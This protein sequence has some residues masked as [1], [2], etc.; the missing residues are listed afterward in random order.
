[1]HSDGKIQDIKFDKLKRKLT[2][3]FQMDKAELDF[4]IYRIMNQKREELD[5]FIDKD[6]RAMVQNEFKKYA[7]SKSDIVQEE[8]DRAV[9]SA[10]D[11]G[12]DP[13]TVEKVKELRNQIK[14]QVNVGDTEGEIYSNLTDFF[15]RYYDGGDFI[16][17]RRYK[18]GVYAIPY[19]GEEVKLHWANSNQYYIKTS[20]NF[21]NYSFLLD[22]GKKISFEI[23][24]AETEKDNNKASEG[25]ER[26]FILLPESPTEVR[27]DGNELVIKFEYRLGTE[28]QD[29]LVQK[30]IEVVT[31][32]D[33][34]SDFA[35]M[36][37]MAPTEKNKKRTV[38]EKWLTHYTVKNSFDYFI[39][40]NLRSFLNQELDFYIKNELLRIDDLDA[41]SDAYNARYISK[42]KVFKHIAKQVI[43]FLAQLEDFQK[44]LWEKKKF[45][46][47]SEYVLTL[48]HIDEKH[49]E[50]ILDNKEQKA[51]WLRLGF[52]QPETELSVEY[53][54]T[55]TSLQLDTK[56]F[57]N[58][59]YSLLSKIENISSSM[60]GIL[61]NS[62]N[63]AAL[64]ILNREFAGQVK[65]AYADPPY[66]AP[67]TSEI[68]YKNNFMHSS[69]IT[70]MQNR[71][72]LAKGLLRKD[73]VSIIAIDENEHDNLANLLKQIFPDHSTVT[74]SVVHNPSGIQG[75]N[76][77][78]SNDF[79][80][81]TY[82]DQKRV[83]GN[84][85]RI[86]NDDV[87][88]F[89][90]VTGDD[91]LRTAGK[92]CFYPIYV[93]DG[94]ITGFGD[95]LDDDIH[96]DNMNIK[97]EDGQVAIYPIDPQGV[98]RKWR[99]LPHCRIHARC[100]LIKYSKRTA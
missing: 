97:E 100:W 46:L 38:I 9:Q 52:I 69:W 26:R 72:S 8:L 45:I 88:N 7:S 87:R 80:V 57:R 77:S 12:V 73:G 11:L 6:L 17:Q 75:D 86:D 23:V 98:E 5:K 42:I 27:S 31:H 3:L 24:D 14:S 15:G 82:P 21:K 16:S 81:F 63:F 59:K 85:V 36:F 58:I 68:L 50:I 62:D 10:Q 29:Q 13:D 19:Q 47:E 44:M 83:I 70:L 28:K 2:E 37:T 49:Y 99:F 64:G 54:K 33:T 60:N 25:K 79:A 61:I 93:K 18:D 56:F 96:P 4:G 95:V 89:R 32:I 67:G 92:N 53:L 78:V 76:L 65:L 20:E 34:P 40:R 91:S 84:E 71:V 41:D 90:D 74:V 48:D 39:H 1:M 43:D 22:N 66:N 35:G 94:K 51:E 55:H 30:A